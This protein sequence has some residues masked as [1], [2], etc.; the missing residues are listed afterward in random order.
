M[1]S[2]ALQDYYI[3]YDTTSHDEDYDQY[4][5]VGLALKNKQNIVLKSQYDSSSPYYNHTKG[6]Q[7]YPLKKPVPP[8]P[9]PTPIDP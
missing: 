1:G 7:S 9:A 4:N 3:I 6:D 5:Y 2:V 8:S